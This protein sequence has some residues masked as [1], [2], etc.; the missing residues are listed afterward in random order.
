MYTPIDSSSIVESCIFAMGNSEDPIQR[1]FSLI[2]LHLIPDDTKDHRNMV[3]K[4]VEKTLKEDPALEVRRLAAWLLRYLHEDDSLNLAIEALADAD[5]GVRFEAV[6][7]L[8]EFAKEE[9]DND[10]HTAIAGLLMALG[11]NQPEVRLRAFMHLCTLNSS[12]VHSEIKKLIPG[13]TEDFY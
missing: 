11:D 5:W 13:Y 8:S 3:L 2:I 12:E 6:Q 10:D 9:G 7:A 1:R 4:A